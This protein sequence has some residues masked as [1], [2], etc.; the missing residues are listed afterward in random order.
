ME[1][2]WAGLVGAGRLDGVLLSGGD[3]DGVQLLQ[4]Y[5]DRCWGIEPLLFM[6]IITIATRNRKNMICFISF[7]TGDVQ[8]VSWMVVRVLSVELAR[9]EQVV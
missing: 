2:E 1:R 3:Q 6:V 5:V 8:T 7:R 4:R 9:T